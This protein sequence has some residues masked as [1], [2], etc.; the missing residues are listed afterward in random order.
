MCAEMEKQVLPEKST[1]IFTFSMTTLA[2]TVTY[3]KWSYFWLLHIQFI[4]SYPSDHF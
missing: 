1:L 3:V 4:G 2:A